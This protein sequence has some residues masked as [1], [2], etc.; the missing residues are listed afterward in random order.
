M[1]EMIDNTISE[2]GADEFSIFLSGPTNFRNEIYPEY[3]ANR[4]AEKPRFLKDCKE[5]LVK[6]YNAVTSE[7]CEADDLLGIAQ[8]KYG[9]DHWTGARKFSTI[10]CSIDKDLRMIPGNHYS[11]EIGGK[12]ARG[13]RAGETWVRPAERCIVESFDGLRRFYTQVLTGDSTDN[14]K[15]AAGIGPVKAERILADCITEQELL[16]AVRDYFS[17]DEELE[18]VGACLWIFRKPNDRWRIPKFETSEQ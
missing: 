16:E 3:K 13:P 8:D 12:I 15:G 11:F 18:M 2:T 10:I 1:E 5:H 4:K 14:V 17:C 9:E 7:G 6:H